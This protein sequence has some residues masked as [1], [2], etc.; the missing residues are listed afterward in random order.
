[1]ANHWKNFLILAKREKSLIILNLLVLTITFLVLGVFLNI[2]VISQ[3]ALN[4][5]EN[6]AQITVF[7]KDDFNESQILNLQSQWALDKRIANV[8]YVSKEEAFK[9]FAEINKNEPLLLESLSSS[10]LPASLDVKAKKIA[11]LSNLA[12]EFKSIDGV[13]EVK[14]FQDVIERFRLWSNIVYIVGFVLVVVFFLIS[15]S[16]IIATVRMMITSKGKELEIQRL[17][18]ASDDYISAPL[19]FQGMLLSIISSAAAGLLLIILSVA[20]GLTGFFGDGFVVNLLLI[21]AVKVSPVVFSLVLFVILIL[22]GLLTGYVGSVSAVKKY[23][24]Y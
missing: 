10:I 15:Y 24:K 21:S 2:I 7:F 18:G 23:L 4:Q 6:Q 12:G 16:V 3:S 5:L 20:A 1:M 9:I 8:A 17:V 22:S 14:F 11:D 13:E 19:I